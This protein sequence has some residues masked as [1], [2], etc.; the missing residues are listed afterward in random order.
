MSLFLQKFSSLDNV[1]L[2]EK[3][4]FF[5]CCGLRSHLIS[6]AVA[7]PPR[8]LVG[9]LIREA[10]WLFYSIKESLL[11]FQSAHCFW[12]L[13]LMYPILLRMLQMVFR[14]WTRTFWIPLVLD[15]SFLVPDLTFSKYWASVLKGFFLPFSLFHCSPPV[16]SPTLQPSVFS[17]ASFFSPQSVPLSMFIPRDDVLK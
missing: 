2:Q 8:T 6:S 9:G 14:F 1:L 11:F 4:S 16:V 17:Q 5:Q 7:T 13:F 15:V 3:N 10:S 12:S